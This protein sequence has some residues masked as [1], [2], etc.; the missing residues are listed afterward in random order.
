MTERHPM[1]LNP[2]YE[3]RAVLHAIA[4]FRGGSMCTAYGIAQ[5][6]LLDRTTV[7]RYAHQLVGEGLVTVQRVREGLSVMVYVLTS[8]GRAEGMGDA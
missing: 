7:Q 6:T 8:A 5:S 2:A 4:T 1:T 3:R